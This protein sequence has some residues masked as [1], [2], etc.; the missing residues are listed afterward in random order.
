MWG[1]VL[2]GVGSVQGDG[3]ASTFTYNDG[4]T[5]NPGGAPTSL[6]VNFGAAPFRDSDGAIIPPMQGRVTAPAG[7]SH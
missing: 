3:N 1:S 5:A 2:G 7:A 6:I 4:G